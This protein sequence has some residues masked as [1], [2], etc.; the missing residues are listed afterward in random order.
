MAFLLLGSPRTPRQTSR[1]ERDLF[2]DVDHIGD[3]YTLIGYFERPTIIRCPYHL[4]LRSSPSKPGGPTRGAIHPAVRPV[5]GAEWGH[6]KAHEGAAG[7]DNAVWQRLL[8]GR[9]RK[10][11]EIV[12]GR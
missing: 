7:K 11:G 2:V 12:G 5:A 1:S 10:L 6:R 3:S 8:G 4:D 9:F